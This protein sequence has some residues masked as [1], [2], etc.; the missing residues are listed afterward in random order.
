MKERMTGEQVQKLLFAKTPKALPPGLVRMPRTNRKPEELPENQLKSQII[1]LL[2]IKG[3]TVTRQQSGL[4]QRPFEDP[5]KRIRIGSKGA[6]DWICKRLATI[7]K[8][9]DEISLMHYFE[10]EIKA[11]GKSPNDDQS[12]YIRHCNDVGITAV[13]FNSLHDFKHWYR[14]HWPE[15]SRTIFD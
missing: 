15:E 14:A 10:L 11:P 4:F 8:S 3:W 13:W 12:T 2:Q 7:R 1:G 5:D 6:C 9:R